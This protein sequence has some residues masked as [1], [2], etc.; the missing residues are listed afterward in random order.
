MVPPLHWPI[1]YILKPKLLTPEGPEPESERAQTRFIV[2]V[3]RINIVGLASLQKAEAET[4]SK[5][6]VRGGWSLWCWLW[7][8]SM[9]M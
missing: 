5:D 3:V 7:Y 1:L 8:T 2:L 6:W 4:A 9:L